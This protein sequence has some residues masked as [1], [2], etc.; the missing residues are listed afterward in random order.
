MRGHL[1]TLTTKQKTALFLKKEKC[2]GFHQSLSS[3]APLLYH[4]VCYRNCSTEFSVSITWFL[5]SAKT[6]VHQFSNSYYEKFLLY[7]KHSWHL[8]FHIRLA[9][10]KFSTCNATESI[11]LVEKFSLHCLKSASQKLY[12][13]LYK[14][15]LMLFLLFCP[16]CIACSSCLV[17]CF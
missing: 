2:L 9:R 14:R 17:D 15:F 13:S 7:H 6:Q 11:H 4:V 16:G 1:P 5:V 12:H 10:Q 8:F 3:G